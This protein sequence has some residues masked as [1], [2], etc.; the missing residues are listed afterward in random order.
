MLPHG[1]D[2]A[3]GNRLK[4]LDV[5]CGD[6]RPFHDVRLG[7]PMV[8]LGCDWSLWCANLPAKGDDMYCTIYDG[9][10]DIARC[11]AKC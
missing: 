9:S 3:Y 6:I 7:G 5:D 2:A 8:G 1:R 4:V 11:S 10:L